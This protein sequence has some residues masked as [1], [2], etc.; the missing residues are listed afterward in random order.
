MRTSVVAIFGLLLPLA[1]AGVGQESLL[2]SEADE[3]EMGRGF[4][5]ELLKEMPAWS[6]DPRVA[7]YVAALG[8]AIVP[9]TDRPTLAHTFTVVDTDEIN[10][11]AVPGG[12][13]YVTVGLL[14]AAGSGAEVATVLA[15]EMGHI[16]A[17]HGVQA[18]ERQVIEQGL[19]DLLGGGGDLGPIV[20]TA[21]QLGTGLVFD[22]DQEYEADELGVQYALAAGF[23]AWGMVDFFTYLQTLEGGTPTDPVSD[24]F[25]GLGELFST[26]PPTPDRIERVQVQLGQEGVARTTSGYAWEA[27]AAFS[28]LA[29]LL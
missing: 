27:D 23:N 1:C 10:A 18:L 20:T 25:S 26:H 17:R 15:H 19:V 8:Q 14:K 13:V 9:H 11:F 29:P 22:Q 28:T 5:A 6:G 2:I 7:Q 12:F 24:I 21:L 16:S 4:H 3:V